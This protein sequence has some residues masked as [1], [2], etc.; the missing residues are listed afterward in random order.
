ML[1]DQWTGVQEVRFKSGDDLLYGEFWAAPGRRKGAVLLVHGFNANIEEFGYTPKWLAAAGYD[2]FAFDQAGFGKSEGDVGRTD[3]DRARRD[4]AAAT[5]ELV[6]WSADVPLGIVGH[7]LGGAYGAA[8]IGPETSFKAA[9]LAQPLDRMWDEIHPVGQA[10]YHLLGKR[11]EKRVAK[12]LDPGRVPY[13]SR[14]DRLFVSPEHAAQFGRPDFL[15]RHVN[16]ANYRM[17]YTLSG[18]EWA[19]QAVVPTLVV[20][21]PHD[22]VVRPKHSMRVYDALPEPKALLEH[23]GGHSCFRDVDGR[24]VVDGIIAWFDRHIGGA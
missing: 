14:T 8:A 19:K 11:A 20:V 7:S 10:V 15:L 21:T 18:S 23:K 17:A 13:K 24:F 12:G 22:R 9:V 16:L 2:C 6:D 1:L 3:L 4:I 5:A